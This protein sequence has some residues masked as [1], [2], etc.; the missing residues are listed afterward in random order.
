MGISSPLRQ[1]VVMWMFQSLAP[2]PL[3][4]YT[5]DLYW[6]CH[7]AAQHRPAL[8]PLLVQA[9]VLCLSDNTTAAA[10]RR[11]AEN[12]FQVLG[13]AFSPPVDKG[14][15]KAGPQNVELGIAQHISL[16]QKHS[17]LSATTPV[18]PPP[19]PLSL[20]V[21]ETASQAETVEV[22]RW[23][24]TKWRII[25]GL[26]GKKDLEQGCVAAPLP[27]FKGAIAG[28]VAE[29]EWRDARAREAG[30]SELQSILSG[31][32]E[33]RPV[34]LRGEVA[35]L[36]LLSGFRPALSGNML[37][38]SVNLAWL[39]FASHSPTVRVDNFAR[40]NPYVISGFRSIDKS[41]RVVSKLCGKSLASRQTLRLRC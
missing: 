32:R 37:A 30:L 3:Q 31:S 25:L 23:S 19:Q 24:D 27:A 39:P 2:P 41:C 8:E 20:G 33:A 21:S 38:R 6:C 5:R 12:C 26:L 29:F 34:V 11:E 35:I 4:V 40:F 17:S 18:E 15:D 14:I 1:E 36:T 10:S 13:S 16:N 28:R 9:L 22:S 7:V